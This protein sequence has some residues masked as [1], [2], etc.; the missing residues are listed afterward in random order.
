MNLTRRKTEYFYRI[1]K[2]NKIASD[3]KLV[4]CG[5]D[6]GIPPHIPR[7]ACPEFPKHYPGEKMPEKRWEVTVS[8]YGCTFP[9]AARG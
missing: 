6:L 9:L 3:T 1:A 8:R 7:Q 4:P 2:S 5:G